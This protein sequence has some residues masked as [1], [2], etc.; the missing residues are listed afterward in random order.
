[1]GYRS[2]GKIWIPKKTE[3]KLSSELRIDLRDNW[4]KN[5]E[6]IW[7]FLDWKWYS[8]HKDIQMWEDFMNKCD[9]ENFN[10][11]FVRIGE[12]FDDN[13]IRGTNPYSKF[14]ISKNIDV[15]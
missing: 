3:S 15:Y 13:E 12:E 9:K 11:E 7:S 5:S 1:M 10:Y 6:D 4:E 2:D 8:T 14:S